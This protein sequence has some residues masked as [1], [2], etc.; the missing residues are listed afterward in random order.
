MSTPIIREAPAFLHPII[1][2]NPTAPSPQIAQVEPGS[3]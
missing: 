3:T 1:T 2:A